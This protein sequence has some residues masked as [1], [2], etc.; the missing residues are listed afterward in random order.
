MD[1]TGAAGKLWLL[2]ITY[3]ASLIN[4]LAN[5]NLG[6]LPPL[7]KMYGT[8]VDISHFLEFHFNQ[9]VYYA[10]D[11]K[12]PSESPEKSGQWVGVADNVGDALT[13]INS[14]MI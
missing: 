10:A 5:P 7:Y 8:T 2:C 9:P 13:Y 11:N 14:W 4:Y 1:C 12:W 3:V 6:N